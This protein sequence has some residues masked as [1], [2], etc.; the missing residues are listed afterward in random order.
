MESGIRF[1]SIQCLEELLRKSNRLVLRNMLRNWG[2][3]FD[4]LTLIVIRN[5]PRIPFCHSFKH[6]ITLKQ[7]EALCIS[8]QIHA[9]IYAGIES[10]EYQFADKRHCNIASDMCS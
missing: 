5:T 2:V 10:L 8:Q 7:T 9:K 6:R 1:D 3:V 4:H